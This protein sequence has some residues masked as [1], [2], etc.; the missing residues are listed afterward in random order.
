MPDRPGQLEAPLISRHRMLRIQNEKR[1]AASQDSQDAGHEQRMPPRIDRHGAL[2]VGRMPADFRGDR[3][4]ADPQIGIRPRFG[5]GHTGRL[6]QIMLQKPF[7]Q[8]SDE[9][10]GQRAPP[11]RD[12]HRVQ[13]GFCVPVAKVA[14][15]TSLTSSQSV[16]PAGAHISQV[17]KTWNACPQDEWNNTGFKAVFCRNASSVRDVSKIRSL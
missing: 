15:I 1:M 9:A 16:N 5:A 4:A 13:I 7:D 3:R 2:A 11:D 14:L 12:A 6:S 10:M 17:L 8:I